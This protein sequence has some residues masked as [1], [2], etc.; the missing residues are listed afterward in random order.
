MP[1]ADHFERLHR[2]NLRRSPSDAPGRHPWPRHFSRSRSLLPAPARCRTCAALNTSSVARSPTC[3][4]RGAPASVAVEVDP[5]SRR[6][7]WAVYLSS[8]PSA[9][10][11]RQ[12]CTALRSSGRHQS[13]LHNPQR[14][15][16]RAMQPGRS[17]WPPSRFSSSTDR[18]ITLHLVA[19]Y[20]YLAAISRPCA[21]RICRSPV[22][23]DGR[24]PEPW[25]GQSSVGCKAP[26]QHL[27]YT[28]IWHTCVR[29]RTRFH[30]HMSAWDS[31]HAV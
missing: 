25:I 10:S 20:L 28:S 13:L 15:A 22:P 24:S 8:L 11:T 1:L 27:Q 23:C 19:P 14:T 12:P 26:L 17:P 21:E 5:S 6:T 16:A 4:S 9:P 18:C 31:V 30:L 2:Y 3:F 7:L 29:Y